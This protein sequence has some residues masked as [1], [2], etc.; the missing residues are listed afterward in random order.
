MT[1]PEAFAKLRL[2]AKVQVEQDWEAD[3]R[4]ELDANPGAKFMYELMHGAIDAKL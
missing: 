2:Q 4:K 3:L 1:T